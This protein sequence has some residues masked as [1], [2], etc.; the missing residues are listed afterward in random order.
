METWK[1]IVLVLALFT[2]AL[3][4]VAIANVD[5]IGWDSDSIAISSDN[6]PPPPYSGDAPTVCNTP[7]IRNGAME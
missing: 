6:T 2:A 1:L 5:P 3:S 4:P 7:C